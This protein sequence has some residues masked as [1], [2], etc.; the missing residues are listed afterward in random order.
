SR[1]A[2]Q[3]EV[4][5]K[6]EIQ[7]VDSIDI[8]WIANGEDQSTF[9]EGDGNDFK[10]PGI[11]CANLRNDFWRN[12][13]RGK[14]DPVHLRLRG[15]GAGNVIG[16]NNSIAAQGVDHAGSAVKLGASLRDLL[17]RNQP[18][19]LEHFQHIIVVSLHGKLFRSPLKRTNL[20]LRCQRD[21]W[22]IDRSG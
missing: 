4:A 3:L 22:L 1:R 16:R 10:T 15:E 5:L 2:D 6:K 17:A 9:A 7:T 13:D 20:A 19:F 12:N 21:S 18:D 11:G 14:V 8:E